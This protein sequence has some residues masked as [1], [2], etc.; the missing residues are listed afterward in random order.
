MRTGSSCN[1]ILTKDC[2]II[3]FVF[4]YKIIV[5]RCGSVKLSICRGGAPWPARIV[6][7]DTPYDR[8]CINFQNWYNVRNVRKSQPV[9]I[10]MVIK[11]NRCLRP[12]LQMTNDFFY[13]LTPAA[14]SVGTMYFCN[15]KNSP[16]TGMIEIIE[17]AATKRQSK[18]NVPA[19]L[20]TPKGKV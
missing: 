16:K 5:G 8:C 4:I 11:V 19:K 12:T 20:A 13:P 18:E 3:N 9:R 1:T 10:S 17:P 2:Y 7:G 6:R 14:A 15:T